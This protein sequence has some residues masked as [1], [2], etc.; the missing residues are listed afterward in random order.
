MHDLDGPTPAPHALVAKFLDA[1]S[2]SN[3]DIMA[4]CS[5]VDDEVR[6]TLADLNPA[7]LRVE[8]EH[9]DNLEKEPM[10]EHHSLAYSI[11]P[12]NCHG[13]RMPSPDRQ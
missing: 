7:A 13:M 3:G 12:P 4:S 5:G 8:A 1:A 10:R 9:R 2:T 6:D 11:A